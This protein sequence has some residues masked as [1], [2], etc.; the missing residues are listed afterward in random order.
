MCIYVGMYE[1]RSLSMVGMYV[2]VVGVIGGEMTLTGFMQT[3]VCHNDDK[4]VIFESMRRTTR[5]EE[6]KR[7]SSV[8][9][10]PHAAQSHAHQREASF[11]SRVPLNMWLEDPLVK[12]LLFEGEISM[13]TFGLH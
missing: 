11:L 10:A 5:N 6:P 9:R 4:C 12:R 7:G 2:Y 1:A 8:R 3:Q 13:H